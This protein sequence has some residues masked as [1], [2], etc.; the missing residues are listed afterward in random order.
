[1]NA[2][3][4]EPGSPIFDKWRALDMAQ[5]QSLV[6][7]PNWAVEVDNA[8]RNVVMNAM[9]CFSTPP[10]QRFLLA[11]AF[12]QGRMG[13]LCQ[14]EDFV[15]A[16]LPAYALREGLPGFSSGEPWARDLFSHGVKNSKGQGLLAQLLARNLVDDPKIEHGAFL[17]RGIAFEADDVAGLSVDDWQAGLDVQAF[18]KAWAAQVLVN[19]APLGVSFTLELNGFDIWMMPLFRHDPRGWDKDLSKCLSLIDVAL[20]LVSLDPQRPGSRSSAQDCMDL[21]RPALQLLLP[22]ELPKPVFLIRYILQYQ[23]WGEMWEGLLAQ[24]Q[25]SELD[26]QTA[27]PLLEAVARRI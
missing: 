13:E 14:A 1:M 21:A 5:A 8:G 4:T 17:L 10:V 2:K 26:V 27:P 22:Y 9:R 7:V 11:Q 23:G 25:A 18:A 19:D 6:R 20:A 24:E 3:D 16:K 15:G 12:E